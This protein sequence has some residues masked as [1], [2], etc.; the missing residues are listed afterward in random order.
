M[1]L[2]KTL[3]PNFARFRSDELTITDSKRMAIATA[4]MIGFR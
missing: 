2:V 3:S 1:G 4:T